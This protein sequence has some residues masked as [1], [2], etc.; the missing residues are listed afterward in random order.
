MDGDIISMLFL[1][2]SKIHTLTHMAHSELSFFCV[3]G[4]NSYFTRQKYKYEYNNLMCHYF[5]F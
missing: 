1:A 4:G 5:D 2:T 3:G